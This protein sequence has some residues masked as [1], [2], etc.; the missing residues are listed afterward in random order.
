MS[1]V[2]QFAVEKG[3]D[4]TLQLFLEGYSF[5]SNRRKAFGTN[6]FQTTLLGQPVICMAGEEAAKLFYDE[7]KFQ[8]KG[9]AP[10]RVQKT[11]FGQNAIQTKDGSAHKHRKRLFLSLMTPE[12]LTKLDRFMREEWESA[13]ERWEH[14]KQ[15]VLFEETQIILCKAVCKWAGVPLSDMEA[16]KRARQF[17]AMVDA[18]GGVGPR[19]WRGK[20]ARSDA[21]NWIESVIEKVRGGKLRAPKE[22]ALYDM[23]WHRDENGNMFDSHM[24]AVELI[25]VLRPTVAT[26]FFITFAATALHDFPDVR[27]KFLTEDPVYKQQFIQEVRR[28]YPL[29]P[30]LGA[31]V[32][33]SFEWNGIFFQK[34]MMVLLD[35]YGTNRHWSL[36]EQPEE[37]QPERFENWNESPFTFIPQGGGDHY[38]THRCAGEWATMDI[39]KIS[40]DYL[41]YGISFDLPVQDLQYSLSRMPTLPNSG[42]LMQNV[43]RIR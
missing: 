4:H 37:F 20:A 31:R 21:E 13:I 42:F 2:R 24:A 10:K 35:V 15:V 8:R 25:N 22:S 32:R 17:G 16:P 5:I 36:W 26:A 23:A 9:A 39:L 12:K 41:V 34:G 33:E 6:V 3:L 1:S 30:F 14:Q 28:F 43:R 29:T 18:F 19:N 7:T 38:Q 11:L 40:L 27:Q